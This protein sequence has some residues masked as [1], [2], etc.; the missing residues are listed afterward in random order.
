MNSQSEAID[1]IINELEQLPEAYL[2]NVYEIVRTLRK[3]LPTTV[4][5]GV[6]L[7]KHG[8]FVDE[9]ERVQEQS[10]KVQGGDEHFA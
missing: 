1:R 4:H 10:R 2:E 3:N 9:I 7:P 6:G 8:P 5:Q